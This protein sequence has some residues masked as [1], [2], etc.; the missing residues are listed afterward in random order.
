MVALQEQG[1][2]PLLKP[3][4]DLNGALNPFSVSYAVMGS[5]NPKCATLHNSASPQDLNVNTTTDTN[6]T[7]RVKS[8]N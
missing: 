4:S 8:Q 6:W 2:G 5:R 7:E 3:T 1:L